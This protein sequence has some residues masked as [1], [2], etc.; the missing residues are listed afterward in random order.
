MRIEDARPLRFP[1]SREMTTTASFCVLRVRLAK[2][3]RASVSHHGS[4]SKSDVYS[5][6]M[7]TASQSVFLS[8]CLQGKAV[9]IGCGSAIEPLTVFRSAQ[10]VNG[11]IDS[12]GDGIGSAAA[13]KRFEKSKILCRDRGRQLCPVRD[14]RRPMRSPCCGRFSSR[15]CPAWHFQSPQGKLYRLLSILSR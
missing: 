3:P 12:A 7:Q 10:P 4:R 13:D 2:F 9:K 6:R 8:L 15:L 14:S 1:P 5:A 11:Q